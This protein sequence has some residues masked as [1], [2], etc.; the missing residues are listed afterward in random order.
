MYSFA[1]LD[2]KKAF[3]KMDAIREALI[4]PAERDGDPQGLQ[5]GVRGCLLAVL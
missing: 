2:K 4:H 3:A 5:A 1:D